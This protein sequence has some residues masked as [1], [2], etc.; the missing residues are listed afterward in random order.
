ME[1][2]VSTNLNENVNQRFAEG[3]V[4]IDPATGLPLSIGVNSPAIDSINYGYA[5][6]YDASDNLISITRSASGSSQTQTMTW[7]ASGNLL[8]ISGWT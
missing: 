5:L 2:K 3:V 8:S 7:D 6:S 4:I 1:V